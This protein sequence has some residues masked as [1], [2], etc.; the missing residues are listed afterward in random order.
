MLDILT[1]IAK[2]INLNNFATMHLFLNANWL[3]LTGLA[4]VS[5]FDRI[6][7]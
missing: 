4:I 6:R 5:I 7:F 2:K 3:L 1:E